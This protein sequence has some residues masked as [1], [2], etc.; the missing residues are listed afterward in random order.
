M[1]P[2]RRPPDRKAGGA[3]HVPGEAVIMM[4][5]PPQGAPDVG[6]HLHHLRPAIGDALLGETDLGMIR[7]VVEEA[8]ARGRRH[9][10]GV[11]G[12][13]IALRDGAAVGIG[14]HAVLLWFGG[15]IGRRR[16]AG[17]MFGV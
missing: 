12:P 10:P 14:L 16:A 2:V 9:P 4:P 17:M 13:E 8:E 5:D 1:R 6:E 11:E 7:E 3:V 15:R